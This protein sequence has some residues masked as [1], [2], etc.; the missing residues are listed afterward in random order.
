[1][2]IPTNIFPFINI[3]IVILYIALIIIGYTKGFLF[4]LLSLAYTLISLLIAWIIS[5]VFAN[6]YPII[7]LE[8]ISNE[9]QL[10]SKLVNLDA[11][12]NTVLYFVIVFLV[13]KVFYWILAVVLK[14]MNKLPVIGTFNKLLGALFGV[15]NATL[16]TFM[17]SLL[18]SLPVI[19]NGNE[20]KN[21]TLFKYISN[22]SQVALNYV[23]EN[24]D[25]DNIKKQF[26]NFDI[27]SARDEFKQWLE[28]NSKNE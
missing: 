22:Y 18:L 4:E 20:V 28:L 9:T 2:S 15:I 8:N 11:I 7:K 24:V 21:G 25:L 3:F 23:I 13:L 5:P 10:M 12:V 6:I 19:K 14:G 17:L 27:D 26:D 1:M 16:I